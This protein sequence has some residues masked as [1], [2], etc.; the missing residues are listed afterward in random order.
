MVSNGSTRK[1]SHN[2]RS[3]RPCKADGIGKY[4]ARLCSMV[5]TWKRTSGRKSLLLDDHC[6]SRFSL[7][8]SG[9]TACANCCRKW[10]KRVAPILSIGISKNCSKRTSSIGK[11][12]T[13]VAVGRSCKGKLSF[14]G[15]ENNG[16]WGTPGPQQPANLSSTEARSLLSVSLRGMKGCQPLSRSW[17]LREATRTHIWIS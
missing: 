8:A 10:V 17:R 5:S 15:S 4:Y 2:K 16:I 14:A 7:T 13:P 1:S 12:I 3:P 9:S 6:V 11:V